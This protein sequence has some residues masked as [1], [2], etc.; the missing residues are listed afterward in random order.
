MMTPSTKA[1]LDYLR[2]DGQTV[3]PEPFVDDDPGYDVQ[4]LTMEM[5]RKRHQMMLKQM[6]KNAGYGDLAAMTNIGR[7]KYSVGDEEEI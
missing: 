7:D 6:L 1:L 3:E 4:T 2:D 5:K